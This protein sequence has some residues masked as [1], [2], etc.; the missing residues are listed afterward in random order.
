[1]QLYTDDFLGCL[2]GQSGSSART[3]ADTLLRYLLRIPRY[4]G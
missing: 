2:G 4:V 1:M 3:V